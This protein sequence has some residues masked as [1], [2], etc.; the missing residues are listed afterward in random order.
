L[1]SF[2]RGMKT[3]NR[4]TRKTINP[5]APATMLYFT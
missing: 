5:I 1:T 4:N 2:Q 3:A